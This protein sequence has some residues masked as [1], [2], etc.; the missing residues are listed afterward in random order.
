[1]N[2]NLIFFPWRL[3][4]KCLARVK[5]RE[6]CHNVHFDLFFFL[7]TCISVEKL[8]KTK[9]SS[10]WGVDLKTQ[11]AT[12]LIFQL[13]SKVEPRELTARTAGAARCCWC[14]SSLTPGQVSDRKWRILL[15]K[16]NKKVK[17]WRRGLSWSVRDS[18]WS[19]Q[20][21]KTG[22]SLAENAT[23]VGN[24]QN[25]VWGTAL[26]VFSQQWWAQLNKNFGSLTNNSLNKNL[27][28]NKLTKR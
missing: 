25:V 12:Q 23:F 4:L 3:L 21:L 6:I 17:L 13:K 15:Q 11:K 16:K 10:K 24:L 18:F 7:F 1:M 5:W 19:K 8:T 22:T 2:Y 26:L 20:R 28:F 27:S 9:T 14:V